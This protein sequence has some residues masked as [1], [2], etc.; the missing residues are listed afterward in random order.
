MC[1]SDLPIELNWAIDENDLQLKMRQMEGFLEKGRKVEIVL[2]NKKRQRRA[3]AEEAQETL[4]KVRDK[5]ADVGATD[6][7]KIE[8]RIGGQATLVAEKR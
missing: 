3:T 1:S 6:K 8:G 5:I 7:D 2:A 4:R